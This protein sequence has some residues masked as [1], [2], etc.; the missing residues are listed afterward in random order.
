[1]AQNNQSIFQHL[2]RNIPWWVSF[3]IGIF[4]FYL[5]GFVFPEMKTSDPYMQDF[6]L[7]APKFAPLLSILFITFAG[8]SA[9]N[10]WQNRRK[11]KEGVQ[12]ESL[13]SL[14][15]NEFEATLIEVY[16]R[17]GFTVEKSDHEAPM[18]LTLVKGELKILVLFRSWKK[19]DIGAKVV[20]QFAKA[21]NEAGAERGVVISLGFFTPE[22]KAFAQDA[23]LELLDEAAV[24]RLVGSVQQQRK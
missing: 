5:F 3:S 9:Y 20:E 13:S 24:L 12:V 18:D 11:K 21:V 17:K 1:M 23:P 2:T 8:A 6:Y 22:A 14:S 10:S 16:S 4:L 7:S 19:R 15:W